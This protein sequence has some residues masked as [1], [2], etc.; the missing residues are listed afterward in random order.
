M[1][2]SIFCFAFI[3]TNAV[4]AQAADLGT[5]HIETQKWVSLYAGEAEVD[6]LPVAVTLDSSQLSLP[7]PNAIG[8]AND[9]MVPSL[10]PVVKREYRLSLVVS[11]KPRLVLTYRMRPRTISIDGSPRFAYVSDLDPRQDIQFM[12]TTEASGSLRVAYSRRGNDGRFTNGEF[13]LVP[14]PHIL[15]K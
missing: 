10:L 1:M 3:L 8:S 15:A 5:T 14:V 12:I 11:Q 7:I 4:M 6:G 13:A 2:R 9:V